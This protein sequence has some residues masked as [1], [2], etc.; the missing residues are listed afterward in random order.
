MEK[1][2]GKA[3]DVQGSYPGSQGFQVTQE[4]TPSQG[5][6]AAVH[7]GA[8]NT[9]FA[10]A[11]DANEPRFGKGKVKD[12]RKL[13]FPI[14]YEA[15]KIRMGIIFKRGCGSLP[16]VTV[17]PS[18]R[19]ACVA[20]ELWPEQRTQRGQPATREAGSRRTCG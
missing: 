6:N 15:S 1:T 18:M 9:A 8:G 13:I 16:Q 20:N 3:V 11:A 17:S 5:Q 19:Q 4:Q 2:E 7:S 14:L 12:E 10:N